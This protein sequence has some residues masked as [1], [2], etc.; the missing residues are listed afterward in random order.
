MFN[1]FP[2]ELLYN[3]VSAWVIAVTAVIGVWNYFRHLKVKSFG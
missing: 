1:F 2:G 3:E